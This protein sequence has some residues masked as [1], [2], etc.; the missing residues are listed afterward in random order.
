MKVEFRL[1]GKEVKIETRSD[2]RLSAILREDLNQK[3]VREACKNGRCGSCLV[4]LDDELVSS[5]LI[6]AFAVRHKKLLT[7]EGFQ[8]TKE[9]SDIFKGFTE[10]GVNLCAY[11]APARILAAAYILRKSTM[12]T[13][14]EIMD[15][16]SSVQCRCTSFSQ[17]KKG[18][19]QASIHCNA[20]KNNDRNE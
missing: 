1:N 7:I 17:L 14:D 16:I 5:C 8:Q 3:G 18:I 15:N 2:R 20:R 12:A 11:C 10:A 6:P 19:L 13:E 4:L 9:F